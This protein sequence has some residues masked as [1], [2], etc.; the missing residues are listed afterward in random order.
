MVLGSHQ[1]SAGLRNA[2]SADN[3]IWAALI[4]PKT[5]RAV[6][7]SPKTSTCGSAPTRWGWM[8]EDYDVESRSRLK[9]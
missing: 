7:L 1:A 5:A 2:H 9:S 3:M 6:I 4:W 8:A